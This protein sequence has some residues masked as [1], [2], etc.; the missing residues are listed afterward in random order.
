MVY[1][2]KGLPLNQDT[3]QGPMVRKIAAVPQPNSHLD[4]R[5]ERKNRW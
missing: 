5:S 4:I 1:V 2:V 3:T